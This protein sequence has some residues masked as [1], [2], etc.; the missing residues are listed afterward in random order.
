MKVPG[1]LV[2]V[3]WL[4]SALAGARAG[5]A[6]RLHV[7]DGSYILP[8]RDNRAAFEACRIPGSRFFDID[9]VCDSSTRSTSSSWTGAE[10]ACDVCLPHML[11]SPAVFSGWCAENGIDLADAGEHAI[12]VYDNHEQGIFGSPRVAWTFNCFGFE[13]VA[14]LDGGLARWRGDGGDVETGP[15]EPAA[16]VA[17]VAGLASKGEMVATI[18]DVKRA[19]AGGADQ[20]QILDAR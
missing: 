1:P 13:N 17:A 12:V 4:R 3:R 6:A 2:S 16:L 11:P 10:S 14:V 19:S 7:V 18:D 5:G 8:K 15:P 20:P 9:A